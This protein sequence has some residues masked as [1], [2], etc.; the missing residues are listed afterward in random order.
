MIL[1]TI[2]RYYSSN[3]AMYLVLSIVTLHIGTSQNEKSVSS[4]IIV[5]DNNYLQV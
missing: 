5:I 4:V 1:V 2:H 3:L